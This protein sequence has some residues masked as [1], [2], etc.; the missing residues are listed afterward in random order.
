MTMRKKSIFFCCTLIF[1]SFSGCTKA[2][3]QN[4]EAIPQPHSGLIIAGS[5]TNLPHVRT[6]VDQFNAGRNL[7]LRVPNSIGS[8]GA[9]KGIREGTIDLGFTSRALSDE[10]KAEG[11]KEIAYAKSG[12]MVTCHEDVP[13]DEISYA[14]LLQIYRGEKTKWSNSK[15]IV[16]LAMYLADSTNEVLIAEIPGFKE[17][18][19][20][21]IK[22]KR[23]HEFYNNQS[24]EIALGK[25]PSSIGF[26]NVFFRQGSG[27]KTIRVNGVA[28]L[29][30]NIMNGSYR[31]HKVLYFIYKDPMHKDVKAFIDFVFSSQGRQILDQCD[32]IPLGR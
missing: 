29:R 10:E 12:L 4:P 16:P 24:L 27:L 7:D 15:R 28:P 20:D 18:L 22:T 25:T 2:P 23:V 30:E 1:L 13:D 26:S 9:I 6:L 3:I 21:A 14:E 5:G 31:L 19:T 32:C 8:V 11:I 17:A